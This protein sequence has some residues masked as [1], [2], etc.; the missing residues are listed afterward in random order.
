VK[1]ANFYLVATLKTSVPTIQAI[2]LRM[3]ES[4]IKPHFAPSPR[5]FLAS[6]SSLPDYAN[7]QLKS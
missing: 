2:F 6:A 1:V 5:N 4:K 7:H 3:I